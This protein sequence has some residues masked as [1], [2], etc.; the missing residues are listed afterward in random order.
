MVVSFVCRSFVG[1][2]TIE[3]KITNE[4]AI[5][6][7][8]KS[9]RNAEQVIPE[10]LE[11]LATGLKNNSWAIEKIGY[12]RSD[13]SLLL[14]NGIEVRMVGHYEIQIFLRTKGQL[15][16]L[17]SVYHHLEAL[18][19]ILNFIAEN[20]HKVDLYLKHFIKPNT[21]KNSASTIKYAPNSDL[22]F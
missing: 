19:F 4:M 13:E 18:R 6:N 14:Q 12:R 16:F 17:T 9:S 10:P 1:V 2:K 11:C 20:E 15:I 21:E 3:N 7:N 22:P 5:Q 8:V